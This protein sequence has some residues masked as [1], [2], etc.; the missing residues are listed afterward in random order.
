VAP[1]SV[2]RASLGVL[3]L[4]LAGALS[5]CQEG[6]EDSLA[7]AQ[8]AIAAKQPAAALIHLKNAAASDPTSAKLRF[9]LGQQYI[10]TNDPLSAVAEFKRARELKYSADELARPLADALL[11]TGQGAQV[12]A[13]VSPMAVADPQVVASVQAAIAWAHLGLN[14]LPAARQA[15]DKAEKTA[16][17]TPETRMIRSRLADAQGHAEEALT[18]V[19]ALVRD[20]PAHDN[21]WTFKGQLH[22]RQP[23]GSKPALEAYAKA[24]SINPKNFIALASSVGIQV[25]NKDY[26]AAHEGLEAMR[27]LNPKAFMTAYYDGQ[28]KFLEGHYT[29]ARSQ[30]QA[31]LNLAPD[32]TIALLASGLN[33]LQLKAFA[34]A[35]NQLSRVIRLEPSN[36]AA[37]FHLA[38]AYLAEGKPGQATATLAPL[39][40]TE[41]PPPEALLV[42]AQ[43][44]LLQG[45]SKGAD[46]LFGRAAKL[47]KDNSSVR[48]ALA[49][50]NSAKGNTDAA[51]Q[52]L[53]RI[54]ASS[55][56]TEANL[57]LIRVHAARQEYPAALAAIQALERKQPA[58]PAA[59][60]LRGQVLLKIGQP[61]EARQAFEAA[62][63]KNPLY[64]SSVAN[65]AELDLLDGQPQQAQKRLEAQL[66]LDPTQAG[67]HL[68]LAKLAQRTGKNP[69]EVLAHLEQATRA[70]PRNVQARLLL[71]ERHVDD[72]NLDKALEAARSAVAAVPDNAQLYEALARSLVGSGDTRQALAT[73]VKLTHLAPREPAGYLGQA[74]V[75]LAMK[76]G[77]GASKVLQQL[78]DIA[79]THA[80]ARRLMVA[81]ALLQKQPDKAL[82]IARE[83]QRDAPATAQGFALEGEV[84]MDQKRW[85]PAAAAFRAAAAKPDGESIVTWQYTALVN[86][87]KTEE[88]RR[89]ATDWIQQHPKNP[90][91]LRHL[92]GLAYNGG[93]PAQAKAYY[94]QALEIAPNDVAMLNN[95]A[96]ILVEAKDPQ[97]LAIAQRAAALAPDHPNVLDTLALSYALN[98]DKPKAIEA[99]RRALRRP[100]SPATLRLHLARLYVASGDRDKA[101]AELETLRDLGRSFPEQSEVRQL[102]AQIL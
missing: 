41:T 36:Q 54:A 27:K 68:G 49:I 69:Q 95:L 90:L 12:L 86:A 20:E 43:A 74:S 25:R 66:K 13:L 91:L 97:A 5:G 16:S 39:I 47:H 8:A 59:D 73:Y 65:L 3:A 83:L 88:A 82:A 2:H 18:R 79:P 38:Q 62:L 101:R 77:S 30:F 67:I 55:D 44:R 28:L 76:D 71:I 42:A 94:E 52:E 70:D 31:A 26:Q 48:L 35:E 15:V 99:L 34:L 21:A 81:T 53:A 40:D 1:R 9:L 10:A 7:E 22:E 78:L 50:L 87:N 4:A 92:A 75:F 98:N 11:V 14:D 45:D 64:L 93:K 29:A 17:P 80:Q 46:Q 63:K 58:S 60:D 100:N 102:L 19:D 24:L 32:S 85:D 56:A 37:R 61:A 72:G 96:W 6:T 57:Q 51:V 89:V 23:G 33:E 84:H